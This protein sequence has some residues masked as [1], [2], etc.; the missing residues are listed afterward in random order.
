MKNITNSIEITR[1]TNGGG[2]WGC[3]YC[4]YSSNSF[5]DVCAHV[6]AHTIGWLENL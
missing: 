3:R 2:R 6:I 1:S 5:W 4:G